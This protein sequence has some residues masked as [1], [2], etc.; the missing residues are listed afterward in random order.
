MSDFFYE[1]AAKNLGTANVIVPRRSA[2]FESTTEHSHFQ[3]VN[4]PESLSTFDDVNVVEPRPA[5]RPKRISESA[6]GSEFQSRDADPSSPTS[7]KTFP[8]A[9]IE[10]SSRSISST[11]EI[12]PRS[13]DLD[14]SRRPP[15]PG[16]NTK[17]VDQPKDR[18]SIVE[19]KLLPIP[20]SQSSIASEGR[21]REG[22]NQTVEAKTQIIA[23]PRVALTRD[24]EGPGPNASSN[25]APKLLGEQPKEPES[26]VINITIGR[27]EVRASPSPAPARAARAQQPT[28]SL[29]EFLK[30]RRNGGAR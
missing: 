20:V 2:L 11:S 9:A 23:K 19:P 24:R 7:R 22:N 16:E 29:D 10:P 4:K 3:S 8:D 17:L 12:D 21:K 25:I 30:R 6:E 27:V 15:F 5:R 1:L 13:R 14:L 26:P 28:V 18:A